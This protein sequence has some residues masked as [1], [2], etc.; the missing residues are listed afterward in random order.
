M[1]AYVQKHLSGHMY[2]GSAAETD[3]DC[4]NCDGANCCDDE[5]ICN[6]YFTVD[7]SHER[8]DTSEEA[9]KV[10]D[11]FL[12]GIR[13]LLKLDDIKIGPLDKLATPDNPSFYLNENNE[14]CAE[15]YLNCYR[16]RENGDFDGYNN[17][18]NGDTVFVCNPTARDHDK[19]YMTALNAQVKFQACK[20][21]DKVSGMDADYDSL[22]CA[23]IG[24][25]SYETR[26]HCC[27]R[28]YM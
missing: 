6:V 21:E 4:G 9:Q 18:I 27:R 7:G 15:A 16:K 8:F 26:N 28:I 25:C 23:K 17:D 5:D 1:S 10:G 20:R 24:A 11:D 19:H 3:S 22:D 14:L 12:V 13:E 2:A